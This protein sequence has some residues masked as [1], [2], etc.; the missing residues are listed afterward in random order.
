MNNSDNR[1]YTLKELEEKYFPSR[2]ERLVDCPKC[3]GILSLVAI[4]DPCSL[5]FGKGRIK[6]KKYRKYWNDE[7]AKE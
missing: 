4:N 5:C 2:L 7:K 1:T 6:Y 3:R